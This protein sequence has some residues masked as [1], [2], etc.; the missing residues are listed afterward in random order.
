MTVPEIITNESFRIA[1]ETKTVLDKTFAALQ[2]GLTT[3]D[4]T[5]H[6]FIVPGNTGAVTVTGM[7]GGAE[8]QHV[9]ILGDGNTT[10]N[11]NSGVTK[12]AEKF[13]TNTAANKL[14]AANKVYRFT[15][16]LDVGSSVNGKWYEDA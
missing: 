6:E 5:N 10:I 3:L 4:A 16:F 7:K 8:T 2:P 9:A 12:P 15:R 11:H 1:P 14:L 13:M